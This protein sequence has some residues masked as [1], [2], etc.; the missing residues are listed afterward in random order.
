[1][2]TKLPASSGRMP[3]RGARRAPLS[4]LAETF[5]RQVIDW[6]GQT[7]PREPPAAGLNSPASSLRRNATGPR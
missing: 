5:L 6:Q 2:M 1:V 3:P 7:G 4:D